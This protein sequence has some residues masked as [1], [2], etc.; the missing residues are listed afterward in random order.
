MSDT[1]KVASHGHPVNLS[2]EE[3]GAALGRLGAWIDHHQHWLLA[4]IMVLAAAARVQGLTSGSLYRDDAWVALTNHFSLST[5]ANML[6]TTPGFTLFE[7]F[8]TG[9]APTTTWFAQIPSLIAGLVAIWAIFALVTFFKFEAWISLTCAFILA[10]STEATIY[11]THVK[12]YAF[13]LV[14]AAAL[15]WLGE[16]ARRDPR[17]ATLLAV[18]L[19]SV[20]F[21]AWSFTN[22]IV[23]AGVFI[24]LGVTCLWRRVALGWFAVSGVIAGSGVT[25]TFIVIDSE[26]TTALRSFWKTNYLETGSFHALLASGEVAA[27]GLLTQELGYH[28]IFGHVTIVGTIDATILAGLIATGL[29]FS[30]RRQALATSVLGVAIVLALFH[31][32]PIGTNR[33][34]AYLFPALLLLVA[35][36]LAKVGSVLSRRAPRHAITTLIAV[37]AALCLVLGGARLAD[38]PTYPGGNIKSALPDIEPTLRKPGG[39][40]LVQGAA[41][42]VWAYYEDPGAHL[43]FGQNFNTGF[44]VVSNRQK[45]IIAPHTQHEPGFNAEAIARTVSRSRHLVTLNFYDWT[46]KH[47]PT[48]RALLRHCWKKTSQHLTDQFQVTTYERQ[49]TLGCRLG[50]RDKATS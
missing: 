33:T 45:I 38:V 7:R 39:T 11:A 43:I 42:W 27:R 44:T 41:R 9:L 35:S 17:R 37:S 29:F 22:T 16:R 26:V 40:L 36:G 32:V 19:A 8:W 3:D 50:V 46:G 20:A 5:S 30:W 1:N 47:D 31:R 10:I 12:P 2:N 21:A 24:V 34:D 49:A 48:G 4:T 28:P 14:A 13:D 18:G 23:V 25:L 15:L 6:V